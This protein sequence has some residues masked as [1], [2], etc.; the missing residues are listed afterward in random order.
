MTVAFDVKKRLKEIVAD[1]DEVL[2]REIW[3]THG[4]PTGTPDRRWCLIGG[5]EWASSDWASNRVREEQFA[6]TVVLSVVYAGA[7]SSEV[8]SIAADAFS[9]VESVVKGN[10]SIDGLVVTSSL[11]PVRLESFPRADEYEAQFEARLRC[12]A[13]L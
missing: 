2:S 10:P 7:Q 1:N 9:A 4:F 12:T 13:R 8:E 3:V 5:I 6:I 11:E